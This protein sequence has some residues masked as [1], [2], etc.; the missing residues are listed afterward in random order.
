[1]QRVVSHLPWHHSAAACRVCASPRGH[2]VMIGM[3][4][5]Y[6]VAWWALL[7]LLL[8][9]QRGGGSWLVRVHFGVLCRGLDLESCN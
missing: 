3:S 7:L 1:M 5:S 9:Q 2:S 4:G 8:L 6:D